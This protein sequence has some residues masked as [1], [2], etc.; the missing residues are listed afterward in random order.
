MR[1][2]AAGLKNREIAD[3]LFI[4]TS[5]VKRHVANIYAKL[6]AT[7]RTEAVAKA[8]ALRLL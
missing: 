8:N 1:L 7:H 6:G 2:V 3:Q 4:S 5:T